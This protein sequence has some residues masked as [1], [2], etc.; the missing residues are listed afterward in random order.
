MISIVEAKERREGLMLALA[1]GTRSRI[2]EL[3]AVRPHTAGEL[4]RAF[5]IAAPAV[6]RHLRVLRDAGLIAEHRPDEDRRVR[7][8]ALRA[9][10][11]HEVTDWLEGL[12]RAW[13][14]QLD[15][16]KDFVALRGE[17]PGEPG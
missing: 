8:Y 6:S 1:D 9:E 10:P 13:Q 2:L 12:S 7:L 14:E 5:P 16:F 15:S 17:S 4:H 3:L 11:V